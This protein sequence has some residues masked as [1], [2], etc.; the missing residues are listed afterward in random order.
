MSLSSPEPSPVPGILVTSIPEEKIV[1]EPQPVATSE[2]PDPS[3]NVARTVDGS[4]LPELVPNNFPES[5]EKHLVQNPPTPTQDQ[6]GLPPRPQSYLP[7]TT[8]SP[9]AGYSNARQTMRVPAPGFVT[10]T[11]L[12]LLADQPDMVDCPFCRQM[13]VTKVKKQASIFTHLLAVGLFF[14]TLCGVVAPYILGWCNHLVHYCS[15]CDRK[16]AYRTYGSRNMQVV[17]TPEHFR[18]PSR[19]NTPGAQPVPS[20]GKW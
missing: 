16:L 5:T 2:H 11:P 12:H 7:G 4:S 20:Q 8:Q 18:E 15:K 14:G 17:G 1:C 13:S 6:P 10:V 19:Y 9:G 3:T